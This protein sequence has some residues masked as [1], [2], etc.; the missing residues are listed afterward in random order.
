MNK[1]ATP[2]PNKPQ[3]LSQRD[4]MEDAFSAHY[5]NEF[6]RMAETPKFEEL[7]IKAR[8]QFLEACTYDELEKETVDLM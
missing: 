2:F 7:L 5:F 4:I 8:D 3:P 1:H 6:Q